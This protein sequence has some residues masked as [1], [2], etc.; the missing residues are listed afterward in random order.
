MVFLE[1]LIQ[2]SSQEGNGAPESTFVCPAPQ[3]QCGP[4]SPS[5]EHLHVSDVSSTTSAGVLSLR[6]SPQAPGKYNPD[7]WVLGEKCQD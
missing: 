7:L 2:V 3:K 5:R 6:Q 1:V 4:Q